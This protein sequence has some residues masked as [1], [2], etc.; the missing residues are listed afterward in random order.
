MFSIVIFISSVLYSLVADS[1]LVINFF[2]L[3][4]AE[5]GLEP[6]WFPWTLWFLQFGLLGDRALGVRD[7][8]IQ[9]QD[10]ICRYFIQSVI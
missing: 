2:P 3:C 1:L 10:D 4:F 9:I 5:Y 8:E 6:F 7:T